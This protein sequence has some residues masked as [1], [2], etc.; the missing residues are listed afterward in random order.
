MPARESAP[1]GAP[2]WVDLMSSDV[3]RSRAFYGD[4]FGWTSEEPDPNLGGY[5]NFSKDGVL[6]AG[7]MSAQD[8]NMPD[9]WS[10][11]LATDD[12]AKTL[13]LV[14]AQGGQ[15]FVPGMQVVKE[16]TVLGTMAVLSD[17]GGATIGTW[18]PGEHRGF[19]ILNEP[20]APS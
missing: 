7:G 18:Q 5:W 20:G 9:F 6:V 1:I 11:Y 19:G 12:A 8:P 13:E 3:A 17:P 4:L 10:T 15:V 14:A 16:G 2:C